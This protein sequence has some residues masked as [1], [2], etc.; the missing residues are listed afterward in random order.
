MSETAGEVTPDQQTDL[1]WDYLKGFHA[2]HLI[3]IGVEAGL[4]A[5]IDETPDGIARS[6][7]S[8]PSPPLLAIG[9][10]PI[11]SGISPPSRLDANEH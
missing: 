5:K 7:C 6:G 2:T 9:T 1:L 8:R 3:S 4:F 10:G 11:R